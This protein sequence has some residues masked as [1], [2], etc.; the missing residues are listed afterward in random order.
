MRIC[1]FGDSFVNG[2]GDDDG[3]GW[4][5]RLVCAARRRGR[6]ITYYNLGVRRDT[7]EDIAKRWVEEADRRL[8]P[9]YE[10]RLAFAFGANDCTSDARGAPRLSLDASLANAETILR[11]AA[12]RAPTLMIGPALPGDERIEGRVR[13]LSLAFADLCSTLGVP[14]L[15]THVFVSS[16]EIWRR[17]AEAGDGAHPN[18][19]GYAALADY[20]GVWPAF[21]E[22]LGSR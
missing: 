21:E 7:S 20:I 10:A 3:L 14:Y 9:E 16:C 4:A 19:G 22:W 11:R 15:E 17:E 12:E 6:D 1:F 18:R 5:G 2:T 8:P 13:A